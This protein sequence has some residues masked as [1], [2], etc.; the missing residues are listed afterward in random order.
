MSHSKLLPALDACRRRGGRGLR[1]APKL[2]QID[3]ERLVFAGE[4]AAL[5]KAVS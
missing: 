1:H 4:S 2:L 5:C 3:E